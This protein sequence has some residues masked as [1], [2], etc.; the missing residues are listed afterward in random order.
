[1]SGQDGNNPFDDFL[2]EAVTIFDAPAVLV[3]AIVRLRLK[4]GINQV[5]V[6]PVEFHA[7]ESRF[8]RSL[9]GSPVV[10]HDPRNLGRFQR[11]WDF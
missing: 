3:R 2:Q 1:M 11:P 10:L 6:G 8:L 4:E 7:V 5:A 9:G